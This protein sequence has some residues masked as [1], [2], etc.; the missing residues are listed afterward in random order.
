ME[1]NSLG[2]NAKLHAELCADDGGNTSNG[3]E[4]DEDTGSE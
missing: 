2:R 1:P 3:R 4:K